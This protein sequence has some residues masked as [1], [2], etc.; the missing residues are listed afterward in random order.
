MKQT[1]ENV[2]KVINKLV[3]KVL[4]QGIRAGRWVKTY[5]DNKSKCSL[6]DMGNALSSL[7]IL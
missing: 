3:N 6:I 7:N 5:E 2:P 4:K 1:I